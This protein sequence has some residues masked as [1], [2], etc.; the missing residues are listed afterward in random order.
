MSNDTIAPIAP[1]E[2]QLPPSVARRLTRRQRGAIAALL[3]SETVKEAAQKCE[4]SSRTLHY[5]RTRIPAF[6]EALEASQ[7]AALTH[8]VAR[9][10]SLFGPA[11]GALQKA[12]DTPL[13]E[14]ADPRKVNAATRA[15]SVLVAAAFRAAEVFDLAKRVEEL[16]ARVGGKEAG[17]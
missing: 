5:W 14:N 9:L 7:R 1:Q 4:V 6:R 17:E 15:A 12:L 16:E 2:E 10:H 11:L 13:K 8:A 3:D